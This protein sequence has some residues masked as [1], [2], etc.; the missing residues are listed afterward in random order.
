MHAA[1]AVEENKINNSPRVEATQ[2]NLDPTRAPVMAVGSAGKTTDNDD[3]GAS[4]THQLP[5][6]AV[7]A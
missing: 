6:P 2:E 3:V 4:S 7:S 1:Q 5:H